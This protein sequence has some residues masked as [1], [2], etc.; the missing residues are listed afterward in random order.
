MINRCH[1]SANMYPKETILTSS[2]GSRLKQFS[3]WLLKVIASANLE[4]LVLSA[5]HEYSPFIEELWKNEAIQVT[6]NRRNNL[7]KLPRVATFFSGA[8][9]ITSSNGLASMEFSFPTSAK[10]DG[11]IDSIDQHCSMMRQTS[12]QNALDRKSPSTTI[13]RTNSSGCILEA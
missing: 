8:E 4:A 2:M 10:A 9:G 12:H 11:Y 7:E 6:Y 1:S 13:S 5:S 3:D